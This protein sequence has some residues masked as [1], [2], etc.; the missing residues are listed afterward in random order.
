MIFSEKLQL[1]RKSRGITQE[2]LADKLFVSRQAVA[3][4]ESGQTYP[5][6][7]NLVHLSELFKVTLDYLIK[8]NEECLI[9]YSE[10]QDIPKEFNSF[11]VNAKKNTYAAK[12]GKCESSRPNS[13]DY[14]YEEGKLLYIDTYLGSERFQGQEAVW[15]DGQPVYAMNYSGRVLGK[16][17]SGDFLNE[18]LMNVPLDKPF[19]GPNLYSSNEFVYHCNVDGNEEWFTGY[20]E[21]YFKN[22]K[23]YELY[24][25]GGITK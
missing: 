2:D 1:I 14:K 21:I 20:E 3:K 25:H 19:R 17:F 11:L 12:S 18:A 9:G 22:T 23:V 8:D 24:F 10:L 6:I 16:S 4:W 15:N 13:H 5:D 7:S